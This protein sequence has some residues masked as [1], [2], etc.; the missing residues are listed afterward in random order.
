MGMTKDYYLG[1]YFL[2]PVKKPL[3]M[4]FYF[5]PMAMGQKNGVL[6]NINYFFRWPITKKITIPYN[7]FCFNFKPF[8]QNNTVFEMVTGMQ[9]QI[10][11]FHLPK[12]F[13]GQ[14]YVIMGIA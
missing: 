14:I 7:G 13:L 4:I 12:Y 1:P 8:S 11:R 6:A 10:Q 5:I 2:T 9:K 3:Q